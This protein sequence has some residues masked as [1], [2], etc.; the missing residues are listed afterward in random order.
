MSTIT[1]NILA[2]INAEEDCPLLD[3]SLAGFAGEARRRHRIGARFPASVS[4]EGETFSG[5]VC[6]QSIRDRGAGVYR[7]GLRYLDTGDGQSLRNGLQQIS[8]GIQRQ[9]LAR[10]SG[11]A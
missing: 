6:I 3:V 7:Y 11:R 5:S 2:V 1:A 8:M 10:G 4:F 9:Q